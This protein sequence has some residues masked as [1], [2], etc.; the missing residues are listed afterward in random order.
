[1]ES[2]AII[3]DKV[4]DNIINELTGQNQIEQRIASNINHGVDATADKITE[5]RSDAHNL[6]QAAQDK[7]Y[8]AAGAVRK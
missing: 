8:G 1:M 7:L 3:S 6:G 4:D 5:W 2:A